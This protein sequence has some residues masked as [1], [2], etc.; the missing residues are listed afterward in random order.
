MK[1]PFPYPFR[2]TSFLKLL[3]KINK[4]LR[5]MKILHEKID[6]SMA[7]GWSKSRSIPENATI[8]EEYVKCKKPNCRRK[9][10][11]PYYYAYWKDTETKKLRKKYIGR[12]YYKAGEP[13]PRGIGKD[14]IGELP[15]CVFDPFLK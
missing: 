2:P 11:G 3:R 7:A 12:H 8:R 5:E 6:L 1:D 14:M 9:Q 10:H 13:K 4:L 15:S